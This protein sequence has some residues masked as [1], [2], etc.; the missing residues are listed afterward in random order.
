MPASSIFPNCLSLLPL[1]CN[2][3]LF[4]SI[5]PQTY[6]LS[7]GLLPLICSSLFFLLFFSLCQR[8]F[9][10]PN[11]QTPPLIDSVLSFSW[12]VPTPILG[13]SPA[14]FAR[15]HLHFCSALF[16]LLLLS[17]QTSEQLLFSDLS[18]PA[19]PSPLSLCSVFPPL[20]LSRSPACFGRLAAE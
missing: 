13:L 6:L 5:S 18:L 7:L 12:P 3:S 10:F 14:D 2:L 17:R 8:I 1:S 15:Q 19:S 20:F 4:P 9:H 11:R 16:C